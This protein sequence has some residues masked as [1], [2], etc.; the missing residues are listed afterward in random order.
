MPFLIRYPAEIKPKSTCNDIICNVDFAATWLD[1]AGIV[2]PSYMQGT[3]F[4]PLLKG[5]T[6]KDWQQVAYHRY[7]MHKDVIHDAYAHYGV[8]DLR[9]KLI[10]WYCEDFGLE[11]TSANVDRSRWE[12]NEG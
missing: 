9:H 4:R 6:P 3:S 5:Q 8:R 11:G 12:S 7:W 1:Y 10:Y 2:Q